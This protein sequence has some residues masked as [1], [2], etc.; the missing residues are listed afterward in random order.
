MKPQKAME[1]DQEVLNQISQGTVSDPA[2]CAL[3]FGVYQELAGNATIDYDPEL[4]EI[5]L[6][7]N[8]NGRTSLCLPR[9]IHDNVDFTAIDRFRKAHVQ[10]DSP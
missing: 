8:R 1:Q 7:V 4:D 9:S 5:F 10:D 6:R 3:C 2:K